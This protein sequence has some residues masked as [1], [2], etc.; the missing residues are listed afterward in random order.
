MCALNFYLKITDVV[1]LLLFIISDLKV[2]MV[3]NQHLFLPSHVD[4]DNI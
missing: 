3:Q 4:Y 1:L 2:L